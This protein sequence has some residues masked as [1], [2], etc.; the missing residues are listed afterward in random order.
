[1]T[2]TTQ[3]LNIQ[4]IIVSFIVVCV[5][6]A[7]YTTSM[8]FRR[9]RGIAFTTDFMAHK[10]IVSQGTSELNEIFYG[11]V[12]PSTR[13]LKNQLKGDWPNG[14]TLKY[15]EYCLTVRKSTQ[16]CSYSLN[17]VGRFTEKWRRKFPLIDLKGEIPNKAEASIL[18][19]RERLNEETSLMDGVIVRTIRE[20]N[21]MRLTEM[22]NPLQFVV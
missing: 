5:W 6:L 7:F 9:K 4:R 22:F 3:P 8:I 20:M 13:W 21:R 2:P 12:L 11:A 17:F 15:T 14:P 18:M 1:M 16:N 10:Y 19:H